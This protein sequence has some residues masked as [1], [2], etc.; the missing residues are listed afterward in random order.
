MC[1][2]SR[3]I[4]A[5][6]TCLSSVKGIDLLASLGKFASVQSVVE[7]LYTYI[8]PPNERDLAR[9]SRILADNGVLAYPTD[10]NWALGCD[11]AS[12]KALDRIRRLKPHHPKEQPFS[13]LCSSISM[14]AQ[15]ANIDH[16]A[17][18]FLKKA[19]PGPFTVL[20]PRHRNLP[21]QIKDK[22]PIVGIRVPDSPLILALVEHYGKP[23]ATTSIPLWDGQVMIHGYQVSEHFGHGI[24]LIL[25]LGDEVSGNESTIIDL[26]EGAPRLIRLGNGDP[27]VFG[28]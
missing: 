19:W 21:R 4:E 5:G 22:R 14:A 15:V 27:G 18:R 13:L 17:Y 20:L 23:L 10:V 28:L 11:A 7:H 24:D 25:D 1:C 26:A 6:E 3:S 8:D 2:G 12:V 9:A 16:S